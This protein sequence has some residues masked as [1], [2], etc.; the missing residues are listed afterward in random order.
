M[1]AANNALE[2][3]ILG[4]LKEQDLHGYELRRRLGELLGPIGRL[5]FG[6]LYPALNRLESDGAVTVVKVSESR[7]G[8]T[9]QRGRKVYGITKVGQSLFEEL[10]DLS[11]STGEDDKSFALR[12]AF[13]RYLSSEAR[14]RLLHRRRE[15][16]SERLKET[17]NTVKARKTRLDDY[18]SSLMEHRIDMTQNDLAWIDRLIA[19]ENAENAAAAAPIKEAKKSSA[20]SRKS[21]AIK[22]NGS[23]RRTT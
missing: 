14:L 15:Q 9:T 12:L 19:S 10:L 20:T 11:T 2:L 4:L 22:P 6:T 1:A 23:P 8:L 13:A 17:R 21:K 18:G 5:S 7:T 3:A 16:L